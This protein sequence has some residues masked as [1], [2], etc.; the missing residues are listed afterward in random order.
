[1]KKLYMSTSAMILESLVTPKG[2][3]GFSIETGVGVGAMAAGVVTLAVEEAAAA[4]DCCFGKFLTGLPP[5]VRPATPDVVAA[6]ADN[7]RV[8]T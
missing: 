7:L 6:A 1:M 2:G 4:A 8:T 5:L 3:R